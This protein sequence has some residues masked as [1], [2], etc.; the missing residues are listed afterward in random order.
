MAAPLAETFSFDPSGDGKDLTH[1]DLETTLANRD[2]NLNPPE[3]QLQWPAP[4]QAATQAQAP[5]SAEQSLLEENKRLKKIVGDQGN[6]IGDLRK[7]VET[8]AQRQLAPTQ[9]SPSPYPTSTPPN[10]FPGLQ[11]D[12]YPTVAQ[13][14]DVILRAGDAI[15]NSVQQQLSQGTYEAQ[16]AATGV[17]PE[18]RMLMEIQYPSLRTLPAPERLSMLRVL[19]SKKRE[20]QATTS[21]AN[22]MATTQ[23]AQAGVRQRVFVEQPQNVANIPSQ[24][25]TIDMN[26]WNSMDSAQRE[27]VLTSMGAGRVND[28]GRRG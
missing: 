2:E 26:A 4:E 25:S 15:F 6:Q 10:L 28:W 27:K 1:G 23:A 16:I 18:E 13:I 3:P 8:V 12:N 7:L 9:V 21:N 24:G 22:V 20:E 14:Q 17:S 5:M 19:V 11:P